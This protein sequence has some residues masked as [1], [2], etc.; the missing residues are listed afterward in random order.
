MALNRRTRAPL[1]QVPSEVNSTRP[2]KHTFSKVHLSKYIERNVC[3]RSS[4]RS[5]SFFPF[6][7][8]YF[9]SV[10]YDRAIHV[11]LE[12]K[13]TKSLWQIQ[14]FTRYIQVLYQ[15][16]ADRF[17]KNVT[18][19]EN[20]KARGKNRA[21]LPSLNFPLWYWS[22]LFLVLHAPTSLSLRSHFSN[23]QPLSL[24]CQI[25]LGC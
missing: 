13:V 22:S 15:V 25:S 20:A 10:G 16:T 5:F 18:A 17:R 8:L 12:H 21:R 23:P 2:V 1:T 4:L 9:I 14:S 7:L 6:I 24:W 3:T 19:D 11:S